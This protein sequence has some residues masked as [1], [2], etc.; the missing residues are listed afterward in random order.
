MR[1]ALV[2]GLGRSGRAASLLLA[3]RGW[4]VVAVD[5]GE[6]SAPELDAAGVEVRAPWAAP[7]PD[8]ELAVKSPGVPGDV[9]PVVAA[10][11]AGVP[12]WSEIELAA[13]QLPNPLIGITG[14]NGKTTTTELA[15]HLL[16]AGGL[17]ATACGNQ[18]TPLAG[19]VDASDPEAWLV[20]ECSSFQLEDVERFRPRAAA[21][22]NLAPDHLDRHG[23]LEGYRDAKLRLF[24]AQEAGDLAI[25]PPGL[26]ATGAAP[27]RRTYDGPPG[28]DAVAWAEGGLHVQGL[29][30]VVGWEDVALRGRHNRENA[31]AAAALAAHAGLGADAL[32]AG[33]A[34]FR[35]VAHR[36][37]PVGAAN[38]V[39]FVN[40]SKATNPDAAI[41]ALDA[42]PAGVHLI[43]GGRAKGT[44]FGA[45]AEAA[46][47]TVVRAYLVGE[48]GEEIGR[49]LAREGIP[50]E[51][52]GT[53][54]AAVAAA[55]A[56]A[57][58]GQTVLLSPGCASFDQFADYQERGEA[59]RAAARAAGAR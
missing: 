35:P 8:V 27:A 18:G 32:A 11:A 46:R 40:D 38:G 56:R 58:P 31:M 6:V 54:E 9:V 55:A 28:P 45:L 3:R 44:P 53:V 37:E 1:R 19:L 33:L 15:A 41:A 30:R 17:A 43:A 36:L 52:A 48:A 50:A 51:D 39:A 5:A 25:L 12:V 59:F 24:A 13:R 23:S 29:G 26:D 4:E 22:L 49:A 34:G 14:T 21:L 20:V 47:G 2:V 10:R 42:Y 7:V 16:R 57:V